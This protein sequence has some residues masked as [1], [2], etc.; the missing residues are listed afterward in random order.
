[1]PLLPASLSGHAASPFGFGT[2]QFGAGS[3]EPACGAIFDACRE[4]GINV[5]DTAF[6][7]NDGEAE[8]VLGRLIARDRRDDLIIMSKCAAVGGAGRANILDQVSRSRSRLGLDVIDVMF[9]HI[10]DAE[11]PLE[12]TFSTLAGLQADGAIRAVGVS[13]FSAWQ[14]MKARAVAD[15]L[16]LTID[17][18]QPMYNL[19]KRQAEVELFPMCLSEDIAATPYSPLAGG[20][21]TGKYRIGGTGRLTENDM[22]R[23]RYGQP[24]MSETVAKLA[25]F[26]GRAGQDLA[27]LAVAWMARHPAVTAPLIS[28]RSVTQLA[29]SLAAMDVEMDDAFH[30]A[31]SD[32]TL[33]PPPATDRTEEA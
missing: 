26:A 3:D 4:A 32:L 15:T 13:N 12:D 25:D 21:L 19:L 8:R 23:V 16:G 10:W 27:T 11:T 33:T 22:Y 17:V 20:M 31:M 14:V 5:F 18:I 28:A 7:Y 1:M 9:I 30:A 24:W 6:V 29:P 2:M